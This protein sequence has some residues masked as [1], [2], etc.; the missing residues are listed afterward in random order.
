MPVIVPFEVSSETILTRHNLL[1]NP[2]L[3]TQDN[4][5]V[6][7]VSSESPCTIKGMGSSFMKV[8][9]RV[10]RNPIVF[11]LSGL[12]TRRRIDVLFESVNLKS[13]ETYTY[14]THEF[15]LTTSSSFNN[16]I[17]PGDSAILREPRTTIVMQGPIDRK[18]SFTLRTVIHYLNSYPNTN[19]VLSTWE[20]EDVSVFT[21]LLQNPVHEQRFNIIQNCKPEYPGIGNINMQIISTQAGIRYASKKPTK[22][23]LKTRTD[24]CMFSRISLH[25]MESLVETYLSYDGSSRILSSSQA[26]FLLRPYGLSDMLTFGEFENVS[27]FWDVALDERKISDLQFPEAKTLR[28]EAV[29]GVSEIYLTKRFLESKGVEIDNTLLQSLEAYRD[30]FLIADNQILDL[31]WNKYSFRKNKY[32]RLNR[33]IRHQELS[34]FLWKDLQNNLGAYL[35]LESLMDKEGNF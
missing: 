3:R 4:G 2:N 16:I 26:T 22:Y 19:I 9:R 5:H 17:N 29:N 20:D 21:E 24:Q 31:V 7:K 32:S 18:S 23:L 14:E 13:T 11:I 25:Y 1:L 34:H 30:H 28:N 6:R 8:F 15:N 33:P 12:G 35:I 10:I 27:S